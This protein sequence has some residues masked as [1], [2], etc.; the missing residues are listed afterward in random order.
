MTTA[1]PRP[2]APASPTEPAP[3]PAPA[4]DRRGLVGGIG[5]YTLWGLLPLYFPLMA[6][7]GAV[8]II[9]HRIVWSLAFCALLLAVTRGWRPF[10]TVL[11]S[12]RTLA[13]LTAA[14]LLL[15][16]NWLVFV[17]GILTDHVVDAALGYY[18]NPIVV[19]TLAVLV[20]HERLRPAQWVALGFGAAAVV[21]IAV[22]YGRV[23]WIALTLASS[24]G[25]YG[26]LKNRVGRTVTAIPGLAAETLVLTPLAVGYL[27][28]LHAAGLGAFGAH[29]TAHT[30]ALVGSGIVTAVPLVLFNTAARRL[31]LSLVGLLQYIAPTL[32]LVIGVA[33]LHEHMPAARW[34]GF[35]LVWVALVLL[36]VDGARQGHVDRLARRAA[37]ADAAERAGG[38][39]GAG[40]PAG[41]AGDRVGRPDD[42][43]T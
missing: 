17:Y 32:Q 11:R 8:E 33:V 16:V 37:T 43:T 2:D 42:A 21:V 20:L 10:L 19:V 1:N 39:A 15:A 41:A 6:P 4:L 7:A 12:G 31:P 29:G 26:L 5:A 30:L 40:S 23:P 25:A 22:G 13:L 34:W 18:I 27:V 3:G 28:W 36:A 38:G 14:A 24:F 35:G 9:A